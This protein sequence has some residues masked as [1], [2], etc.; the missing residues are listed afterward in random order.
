MTTVSTIGAIRVA[1]RTRLLAAGIDPAEGDWLLARAL[2]RSRAYL[3][4]HG[5]AQL[6]AAQQALVDHWLDRR[7]AGEPFAY[8]SGDREFYGRRFHVSPA[9]LIPRPDTELLLEQAL[10]RCR[11]GQRWLDLGTGSGAL[12]ISLKLER[13]DLDV[14]AMD[15]SAAALAVARQNAQTL[16]ADVA[17]WRGS[18]LAAVANAVFD[19]IVAN[20]PYLASDDPH[21]SDLRYE[22]VDALVAG[23]QGL[24]DIAAIAAEAQRVL[25]SGGW[26]LIEHGRDQ[27]AL[28]RQRLADYAEVQTARDLEQR[29]RVTLGRRP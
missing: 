3:I 18:W 16:G 28:A 24:D 1:A 6:D 20:P 11:S 10:L 26:V 15:R 13:P 29:E 25:R 23:T 21:L 14:Y 19:G 27:G 7:C 22:P 5:E 4:A 17:F 12:A 8:L 9:V 2:D